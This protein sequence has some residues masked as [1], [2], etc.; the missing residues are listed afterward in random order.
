[1]AEVDHSTLVACV[2]VACHNNF[3]ARR[4]DRA[5][6]PG[7]LSGSYIF[8]RQHYENAFRIELE[9]AVGY[10]RHLLDRYPTDVFD[11]PVILERR[12]EA[13]KAIL[14]YVWAL[15]AHKN[16]QEGDPDPLPALIAFNDEIRPRRLVRRLAPRP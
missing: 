6:A 9:M 13:A 8:S 11:A 16:V 4:E 15:M 12:R 3:P 1:M 2:V 10:S 14:D 7:A 5:S